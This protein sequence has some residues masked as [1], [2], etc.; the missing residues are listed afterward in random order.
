MSTENSSRL[1]VLN[2]AILPRFKNKESLEAV[3]VST[4]DPLIKDS[5][6]SQIIKIRNEIVEKVI[7]DIP[8]F[9]DSIAYSWNNSFQFDEARS[10]VLEN[11]LQAADRY[12][13]TKVPFCKFTSFFWMYNKNLLRNRLKKTKAAKR[14]KRKT[15]SLDALVS[16]DPEGR[17]SAAY[18]LFR[19][20]DNTPEEY[21]NKALLK[22]LYDEATP[23]QKRILKRLYLGYSQSEIAKVLKVTGTNV[24]TVIRHLRKDLEQLM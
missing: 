11:L 16:C 1:D 3:L 14:D 22:H 9:L 20:E 10:F 8:D 13:S 19:V 15:H 24:N 5:L 12:Q 7:N 2:T 18:D 23:K 4:T 6:E 17:E 21:A